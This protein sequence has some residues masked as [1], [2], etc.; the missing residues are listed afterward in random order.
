MFL[1]QLFLILVLFDFLKWYIF[2]VQGEIEVAGHCLISITFRAIKSES[3]E[4]QTEDQGSIIDQVVDIDV[5]VSL[6]SLTQFDYL[7]NVIFAASVL[8]FILLVDYLWKHF[9]IIFLFWEIEGAENYVEPYLVFIFIA[10]YLSVS[11]I[12]ELGD[13]IREQILEHRNICV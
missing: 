5:Q 1:W 7:M 13:H 9:L 4:V 3:C 8:S 12:F 2:K 11:L 6:E 10:T